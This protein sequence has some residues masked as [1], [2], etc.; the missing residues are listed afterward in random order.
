[1]IILTYKSQ[2]LIFFNDMSAVQV[3]V[4][5]PARAIPQETVITGCLSHALFKKAP[6]SVE[7]QTIKFKKQLH[8]ASIH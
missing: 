3:N 5:L 7:K 2:L 1:M 4:Y 6:T 8:E